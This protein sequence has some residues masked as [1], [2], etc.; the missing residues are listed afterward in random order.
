MPFLV[1]DVLIIDAT[2]IIGLFILLSFQSI[3]SSFI[4]SE[5]SAFMLE[6]DR[7]SNQHEALS[8]LLIDECDS[9]QMEKIFEHGNPHVK[10]LLTNQGST[11]NK[12][13][14]DWMV[15][16]VEDG[17][18]L[19]ELQQ[20]GYYYGYLMQWDEDGNKRVA[21]D[22]EYVFGLTITESDYLHKVAT[23]PFYVNV[24][25]LLMMIPFIGLI[26]GSLVIFQT[27]TAFGAAASTVG[28]HGIIFY[29]LTALT[30]FFWLE[31]IAYSA[32][33]T[34]GIFILNSLRNKSIKNESIRTLLVIIINFTLLLV[35]AFVEML[36]I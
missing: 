36:F 29:L 7:T 13:C 31:F 17:Y 25:N 27:G 18:Y 35:G 6:W 2:V 10:N 16:Y 3:S 22:Y 26:F 34:Q 8:A 21:P 4:E 9:G 14:S 20:T 23:G 11:A 30:P 32:S 1:K 15:E 12:I 28:T 5:S 24:T 19:D 33:M